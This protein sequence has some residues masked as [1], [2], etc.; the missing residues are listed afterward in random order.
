MEGKQVNKK[1]FLL[2]A[3]CVFLVIQ[4]TDFLFH[5]MLLSETYQD[6]NYVWR[7]DM[8]DKMWIMFIVS[9]VF[10]I[11]F[12]YIYIKG[13]AGNR[14]I[15][16]LKY[17]IVMSFMHPFIAS[18]SQYAIYPLPFSLVLQWYVFGL[19]QIPLCGIVAAAVYNIKSGK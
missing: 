12:V 7:K 5:N 19:I 14:L 3:L 6:L 17:G 10:S 8:M 11:L 1:K 16:G 13:F 4:F 18:L 2:A 15:A 9:I